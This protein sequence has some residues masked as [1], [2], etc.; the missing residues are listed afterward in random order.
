[1]T[2]R[3]NSL[4]FLPHCGLLRRVLVGG[5]WS[6]GASC[7]SRSVKCNN[8][9]SNRNGNNGGRL[10]AILG[11]FNP[12]FPQNPKAGLFI[13]ADKKAK[14]KGLM[15]VVGRCKPNIIRI[16]KQNPGNKPVKP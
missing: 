12:K 16:K 13:L 1:M 7:G 11:F 3:V 6:N 15:R 8:L 10:C 2:F 9:S 5:K 14:N 4:Y